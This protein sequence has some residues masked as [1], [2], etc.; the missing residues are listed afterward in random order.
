M[1]S[2][3]NES[4]IDE[5]QCSRCRGRG[6]RGILGPRPPLDEVAVSIPRGSVLGL[7]GENG[8]GKT[9]LIRDTCSACSRRRLA[10][11]G[12]SDVK[13]VA[14]SGGRALAGGLPFGT[15]WICPAGCGWDEFMRYTQAFYPKWDKGP[16]SRA[17]P[18]TGSNWTL[19]QKITTQSQGQQAGTGLLVALAYRPELLT[20]GAPRLSGSIR[21]CDGTSSER[22][23]G[24][25][26]KKAA[27]SCF[28]QHLLEQKW[29]ASQTIL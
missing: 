20:L 13:S 5:H 22:L 21:W 24:S 6:C 28:R 19:P 2:V 7:V 1:V 26:L 25:S 15:P 10:V 11:Y 3:R 12:Y 16:I 14:E 4:K 27:A 29:S 17:A 9:T 23:L 8:A 18:G